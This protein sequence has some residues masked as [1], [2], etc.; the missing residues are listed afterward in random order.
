MRRYFF[1]YLFVKCAKIL[2][3]LL[4]LAGACGSLLRYAQAS[5]EAASLRYEPNSALLLHLV[6]INNQLSQMNRIVSHLPGHRQVVSPQIT[7]DHLAASPADFDVMKTQLEVIEGEKDEAKIAIV[8]EFETDLEQIEDKLRAHAAELAGGTPPV[9]AIANKPQ[10][11][12]EPTETT[13]PS[14]PPTLFQS[15]S[16]EDIVSRQNTLDE[17]EEFLTNLQ[18]VVENP[19]N[20][21]ILGL[22]IT[23]MKQMA[24]LLPSHLEPVPTLR[25]QPEDAAPPSQPSVRFDAIRIADQLQQLRAIVRAA[26]LS[27]WSIDA[28]LAEAT[29]LWSIERK[30]CLDAERSVKGLWLSFAGQLSVMVLGVI[31]A[32]FLVLVLADLTQT[33]LDTAIHT[34]IVASAYQNQ[35]GTEGDETQ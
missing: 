20:G 5:L 11:R 7:F 31:I 3:L 19:D 26:I 34:G 27:D 6:G 17:G 23:E 8:K 14:T 25:R 12:R 29:N 30:K 16:R 32:A 21:R 4:I 1:G 22:A 15:M 28:S 9:P 24:K 13:A 33:L 18:T 10:S 35:G 2:A